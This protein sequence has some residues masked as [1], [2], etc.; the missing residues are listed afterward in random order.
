MLDSLSLETFQLIWFILVGVLFSGY[1]ILD[2]FDLGT[3]VIQLFIKG[4]TNR[5]LT[6]NAVGPVW[7]GNEVWL[8]TGGGA[9]FAAFP[10]VYAGVFS[11]FYLAFMLLLAMLIFRAVSIEFRSKQ[12]MPWWRS[13]WDTVFSLSSLTAALLIGVAMGNVARGIPLDAAGNFTGTFLSLLNPYSL[14]LGVCT[15]ALFAVHGGIYLLMKTQGELQAQIRKILLPCLGVF[16]VLILAHAAVTLI[17][18]PR[19]LEALERAPLLYFVLAAA[20]FCLPALWNF[21]RQN[22]P[23]WAFMASCTLMACLMITFGVTMFPNLIYSMPNPQNSMTLYADSAGKESLKVMTY[24]AM[25][26]VP[27]V[28]A[29]S[30]AIYHVFRGK[31]KLNEHSY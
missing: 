30:A 25:V 12:P 23:G 24:I 2:G 29:Y 27:I 11:G 4:D 6:L 28:L 13:M 15:V 26:G 21:I 3:G 16:T 18:V 7:D 10:Y 20:F 1:A 5:R 17:Y 31:V 22:R 8:I 14:L 19:A 9:L